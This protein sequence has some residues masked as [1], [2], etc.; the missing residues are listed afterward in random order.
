MPVKQQV[1]LETPTGQSGTSIQP[2]PRVPAPLPDEVRK[3]GHDNSFGII[4]AEGFHISWWPNDEKKRGKTDANAHDVTRLVHI[5]DDP[6]YCL[7]PRDFTLDADGHITI[8]DMIAYVESEK[9]YRTRRADEAKAA[10]VYNKSRSTPTKVEDGPPV[11]ETLTMSTE[12]VSSKEF[13]GFASP[14]V[15]VDGE[16]LNE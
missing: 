1:V 12:R 4:A 11:Y 5:D 9:H 8:A 14:D 13:D 6:P 15:K 2:K 16:L 10:S 7:N 3:S